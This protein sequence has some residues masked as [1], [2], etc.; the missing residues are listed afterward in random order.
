MGYLVFGV[1]WCGFGRQFISG[2]AFDCRT[3]EQ[4]RW[5]AS[6][7]ERN[8]IIETLKYTFIHLKMH[9][10][11]VT[12][13]GFKTYKDETTL[14]LDPKYT[15]IVGLNGSG[16]SN[17]LQ[18][19]SF[20]TAPAEATDRKAY[21]HEGSSTAVLSAFVEVVFDNK[22]RRLSMYDQDQVAFRRTFSVKKDIFTIDGKTVTRQEVV[23][24]IES[25]GLSKSNPYNVVKQGK[26]MDLSV[27]TD[28]RRL[29]LLADIAGTKSYEEKREQAMK[30]LAKARGD[31]S[32]IDRI[33]GLITTRLEELEEEQKE[34]KE[35][36]ALEKEKGVLEI[37]IQ[38]EKI[39][40]ITREV[41][42]ATEK[43]EHLLKDFQKKINTEEEIRE[44]DEEIKGEFERSVAEVAKISDELEEKKKAEV[45]LAEE[46][47]ELE[48]EYNSGK[49]GKKDRESQIKDAE[50]RIE[51][52]KKDLK[53]KIKELSSL[54]EELSKTDNDYDAAREELTKT[55]NE[56]E[57]LN[58]KESR[59]KEKKSV[60][61]RKSDLDKE[62]KAKQTRLKSRQQWLANLES[63]KQVFEKSKDV[64]VQKDISDKLSNIESEYVDLLQKLKIAHE[65][66]ELKERKHHEVRDSLYKIQRETRQCESDVGQQESRLLESMNWKLRQG[67]SEVRNFIDQ[68]PQHKKDTYGTLLENIEAPPEL[69]T[70]IEVAAGNQLFNFLVEDDALADKLISC[71]RQ[72]RAGT[73]TVTPLQNIRKQQ[74]KYPK[75]A[76][77]VPL[78]NLI[79]SDNHNV[80]FAINQ[81]FGKFMLVD[82]PDLHSQL[83]GFDCITVEGD[84]VSRK[85]VLTGGHHQTQ[86]SRMTLMT[87]LSESRKSWAA[88]ESKSCEVAATVSELQFEAD[89]CQKDVGELK[90]KVSQKQAELEGLRNSVDEQ[91]KSAKYA[92]DSLESINRQCRDTD[93]EIEMIKEDINRIR[94]ERLLPDLN[95]L[96]SEDTTKKEN[97]SREIPVLRMKEKEAVENLE[98]WKTKVENAQAEV[99]QHETKIAELQKFI[100]N[101]SLEVFSE[102][103]CSDSTLQATKDSLTNVKQDLDFLRKQY[104]AAQ[105]KQDNIKS[106]KNQVGNS[107]RKVQ[108]EK[109]ES[110]T[111]LDK[112]KT[113]LNTAKKKQQKASSS[114]HQMSESQREISTQFEKF[115]EKKL[116]QC[117]TSIQNKLGNFGHVNRKALDQF[118]GFVD[119]K[120]EL[121][122]EIEKLDASEKAIKD[123]VESLDSQ[124]DATLLKTFANVNKHFGDVFAKL[125]PNGTAVLVLKRMSAEQ[126]SKIEEERKIDAMRDLGYLGSQTQTQ[127]QTQT[128]EESPTQGGRDS[129]LSNVELTEDQQKSVTLFVEKNFPKLNIHTGIGVKVKFG[130]TQEFLSMHQLSGGQKTVVSLALVFALQLCD[131]APF[132]LFDEI[133]AALDDRYRNGVAKLVAECSENAQFV[134]TTFRP[135]LL[136]QGNFAYQVTQENRRSTVTR[137]SIDEAMAFVASDPHAVSLSENTSP[138]NIGDS[139]VTV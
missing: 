65:E 6:G 13:R 58:A 117:I 125:V 120:E 88:S 36:T 77:A 22:D 112:I 66:W 111:T 18:A 127:T 72:K 122:T 62:L 121:G 113:T 136:R 25:A 114:L 37:L 123:L 128:Q 131:P 137:V 138:I 135:E 47:A 27:A 34:L 92:E 73:V 116:L 57:Q 50:L 28:E 79:K 71:V 23:N 3:P 55:R 39:D 59:S 17:V 134:I 82:N 38:N 81:V 67:I 11:R 54:R 106:T 53:K 33:L 93:G 76:G 19:I 74:P 86:K 119:R 8:C 9:I 100:S 32:D 91:I 133:D 41:E 124:K 61:A 98:A 21:L 101:A 109:Q 102:A 16:K 56:F 139:I 69:N 115:S 90:L 83:K 107:L 132:Y 108:T 105:S 80:K 118:Q 51:K 4:K 45:R 87:L 43:Y 49:T 85:G 31:R 12:F 63:Q 95:G 126:Y 48:T 96:S 35:V 14:E 97:L 129:I 40:S 7:V 70:A 29:K 30:T 24:A 42:C 110:E 75:V 52:L 78:C 104:D 10:V 20:V 103:F 5:A 1:E 15:C 68:N 60:E 44:K 99:E 26:V 2:K 64:G 89:R 84:L 94:A 46:L 130:A